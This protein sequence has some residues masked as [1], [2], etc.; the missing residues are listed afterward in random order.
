MT[1]STKLSSTLR[2]SSHWWCPHHKIDQSV[3]DKVIEYSEG[4]FREAELTSLEETNELGQILYTDH[5][6]RKGKVFFDEE[7]WIYEIVWPFMKMANKQAEWDFEITGAESYQ[8]TKSEVG[9]FY[10]P[11]NDSLGTKG[12]TYIWPDNPVIHNKTRKMSMSFLLNDDFE[13]GDLVIHHAAEKKLE[14]GEMIFFPSFLTHEVKPVTKGT[15]YSL[16]VWFLGPPW[17]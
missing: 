5:R 9:D 10:L 12:T 17:R 7:Q 14:K 2:Y 13:G 4:K 8:I 15:R 16:V 6:S 11:H 3:C 1:E